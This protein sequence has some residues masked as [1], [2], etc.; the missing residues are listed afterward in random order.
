MLLSNSKTSLSYENVIDI[1]IAFINLA[2]FNLIR[3]IL[4]GV[5]ILKDLDVT[6]RIYI[7]KDRIENIL[8]SHDYVKH[9]SSKLNNKGGIIVKNV[10]MHYAIIRNR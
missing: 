8:S 7:V 1:F 10:F 9:N 5:F 6:Y 2:K 3:L 4:L